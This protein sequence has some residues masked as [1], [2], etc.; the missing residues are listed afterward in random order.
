MER[1]VHSYVSCFI[2]EAKSDKKH[3]LLIPIHMTDKPL[4]AYHVDHIGTIKQTRKPYN[5]IFVIVAFFYLVWLNPTRS[6]D[7][8]EVIDKLAKQSSTFGNLETI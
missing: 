5:Y 3:R 4:L 7:F 6:C 2:T 1:I 8:D